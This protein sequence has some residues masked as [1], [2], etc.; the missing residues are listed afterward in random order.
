MCKTFDFLLKV[1]PS[2]GNKYLHLSSF[3]VWASLKIDSITFEETFYRFITLA[4]RGLVF[5][6]SRSGFTL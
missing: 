4:S 6:S 2:I 5:S 1:I 3:K